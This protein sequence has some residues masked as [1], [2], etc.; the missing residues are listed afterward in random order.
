MSGRDPRCH[1]TAAQLWEELQ[2]MDGERREQVL[3]S[4]LLNADRGEACWVLGH[5]RSIRELNLLR[6]EL[7]ALLGL[8]VEWDESH[9]TRGAAQVVRHT[10]NTA[11][12]RFLKENPE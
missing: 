2:F 8:L 3:T 12:E 10:L 5:K 4:L 7:F 6:S 1:P 11:R 9:L